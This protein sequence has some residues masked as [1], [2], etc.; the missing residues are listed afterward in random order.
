MKSCLLDIR[1]W[2][3]T[4]YNSSFND[5]LFFYVFWVHIWPVICLN[6]ATTSSV[7]NKFTHILFIMLT[8]K[9]NK[10]KNRI[11]P[12]ILVLVTLVIISIDVYCDSLFFSPVVTIGE[13][14]HVC[15]L[16][17]IRKAAI[18]REPI[19]DLVQEQE[20]SC[21]T[22]AGAGWPLIQSIPNLFSSWIQPC[23]KGLGISGQFSS[24]R[25]QIPVW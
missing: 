13:P 6:V 9:G 2:H 16:K 18:V 15:A 17:T 5:H 20:S 3:P 21:K 14:A 22:V 19:Q 11:R 24:L 12:H 10:L 4:R 23:L 1:G 25:I 8:A 7:V